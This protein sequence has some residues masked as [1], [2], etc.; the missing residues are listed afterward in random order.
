MRRPRLQTGVQ[1]VRR[2]DIIS[3]IVL[4]IFSLAAIFLIIPAGISVSD[5]YGLSPRIFPLTVMTLGAAVAVLL[6]VQRLREGPEVPDEPC[7]MGTRSWL[8]VIAIS[9][10][11]ALV[12]FGIQY[13]GFKIVGPL[14]VAA[15]MAVMGEYRHPLRLVLVSLIVPLAIYY[16]FERLFIIQIP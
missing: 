11:L 14:G 2:S 12:Y 13:I 1:A 7:D 16:T 9:A 5:E 10:F 3:G 6:V 8:F 4:T 15:L